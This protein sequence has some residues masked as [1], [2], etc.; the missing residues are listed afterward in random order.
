V[1]YKTLFTEDAL[2]DLE[3]LLDYI[4]ADDPAAAERFGTALLNHVELLQKSP[5]IGVPVS[6]RRAVRKSPV[7]IYYRLHEDRRLI[8]IL[9]FWHA[10]RKPPKL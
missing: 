9:H 1:A 5:R 8:E 10:G 4:R 3:I 7:R 2:V 6:K